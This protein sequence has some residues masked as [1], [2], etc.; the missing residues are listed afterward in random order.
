MGSSAERGG[1]F[2]PHFQRKGEE[3]LLIA[4]LQI[5]GLAVEKHVVGIFLRA[6]RKLMLPILVGHAAVGDVAFEV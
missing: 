5:A 1:H 3:S 2:E 4:N 6:V